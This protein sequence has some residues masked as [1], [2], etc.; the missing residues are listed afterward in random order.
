M[1]LPTRPARP[2]T[3]LPPHTHTASPPRRTSKVDDGGAGMGLH[4]RRAKVVHEAHQGRQDLGVLLLLR[5]R[6]KRRRRRRVTS[7]CGHLLGLTV[8]DLKHTQKPQLTPG[9]VRACC[10]GGQLRSS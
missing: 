2:I 10:S 4:P 9:R 7:R 5:G 1:G 3:T 8:Q 6:R